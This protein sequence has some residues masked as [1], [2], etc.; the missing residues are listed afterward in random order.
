MIKRDFRACSDT[1]NQLFPIVFSGIV[2]SS[3]GLQMWALVGAI[4]LLGSFHLIR[5]IHRFWKLAI[6]RQQ[7][8]SAAGGYRPL[9]AEQPVP[10]AYALTTP[11]VLIQRPGWLAY[12]F[13]PLAGGIYVVVIPLLVAP[14]RV[15]HPSLPFLA[16]SLLLMLVL[17]IRGLLAS[18]QRLEIQAEGLTVYAG[19]RCQTIRWDEVRL[20]AIDGATDPSELSIRYELSSATTI[21]RW[22]RQTSASP[23]HHLTPPFGA[24]NRHMAALLSLIAA[25]TGLPLYDLRLPKQQTA[26]AHPLGAG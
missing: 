18:Y 15:L 22:D 3:V 7:A 4:L 20:F 9:A 13:L 21:V 8:V 12:V 23:F 26:P 14:E 24:Y 6:R 19:F 16:A 5:N 25:K 11:T 10:D 2:W 17:S 1:L